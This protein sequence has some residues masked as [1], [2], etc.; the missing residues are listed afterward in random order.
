MAPRQLPEASEIFLDHVG[1]F[2]ADIAAAEGALRAAGFAPTPFSAQVAPTGEGGALEPTGTGNVCAMLGQ[3][4]IEALAKVAD[5]PLGRE[6]EAAVDRRAGLH[7]AAFAVADAAA[8]HAGLAEAG[9]PVRPLVFMR[10]PV[11]T[12]EGPS[13]ASFTVA[14]VERGAMAEG[15]IQAL[16]HHTEREVWQERWLTH[17]NGALELLG[18]VVVS[19]DPA[20]AAGRFARFLGRKA[21]RAGADGFHVELSRGHVRIVGQ[22]TAAALFGET[23]E[24]PWIAAYGLRVADRAATIRLLSE[25]GLAVRII[26]GAALVAFPA[27]LGEG[28]WA[29]VEDRDALPWL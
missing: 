7:L 3:G 15:R 26:D 19:P 11:D 2:V 9:F 5:T 23:P 24:P 4:Y 10:R 25:A 27:A 12:E 16:T 22:A 20:E 29:F 21:E 28:F 1:H 6:L 17:P 18:V 14:R 13:E 8:F